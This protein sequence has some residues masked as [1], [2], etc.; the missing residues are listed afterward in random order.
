MSIVHFGF[1]NIK[2]YVCIT[3][4]TAL[5]SYIY[6]IINMC[7]L[8]H[9]SVIELWLSMHENDLL[10]K[11]QNFWQDNNTAQCFFCC[12]GWTVFFEMGAVCRFIPASEL[13]F[14]HY[15]DTASETLTHRLHPRVLTWCLLNCSRIK[16]E[17]KQMGVFTGFSPGFHLTASPWWRYKWQFVLWCLI[18][19]FTPWA[20]HKIAC[21]PL[22]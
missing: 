14:P 22:L 16:V 9:S 6:Y 2:W 12:F 17:N 3:T 7:C 13:G 5:S 18:G 4:D 20:V 19:C 11:Y 10:N 21:L 15:F 8:Q 1:F